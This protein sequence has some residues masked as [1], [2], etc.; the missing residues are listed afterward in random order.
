MQNELVEFTKEGKF[1]AEYQVDLGAGGGAFDIAFTPNGLRFAA[2]DD[3]TNSVTIL[4]TT[5]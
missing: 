2:V 1:V 4:R 5:N 3:D